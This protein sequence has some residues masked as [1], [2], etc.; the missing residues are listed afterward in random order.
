[1]R[2]FETAFAVPAVDHGFAVGILPRP[3]LDPFCQVASTMSPLGTGGVALRMW[4]SVGFHSSRPK[5]VG[6]LQYEMTPE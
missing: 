6:I 2:V 4:L 3:I 1:M 5:E